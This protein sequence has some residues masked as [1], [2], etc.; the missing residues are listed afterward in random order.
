[1]ALD[2]K[3]ESYL[4]TLDRALSRVSVSDRSEIIL[5]IKSHVLDAVAKHPEQKVGDVLKALGEPEAVANR[6]LVERGLKPGKAPRSP[7][8]KWLTIGFLGTFAILMASVVFM[9]TYFSPII[10]IDENEE[11]VRILGGLISVN[12]GS[13]GGNHFDL[14]WNGRSTQESGSHALDPSQVDLVDVRFTNGKMDVRSGATDELAWDCWTVGPADGPSPEVKTDG[15][16]AVL[17]LSG[18]TMNKCAVTLPTGLK[19]RLVGS[20][21]R[22]ALERPRADT[23]VEMDNGKVEIELDPGRGYKFDLKLT[24]GR[25]DSFPSSDDPDAVRVKVTMDNG[26]ITRR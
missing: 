17:D 26:R 2:P 14:D 19:V 12:G 3:L 23:E 1:M 8:L 6:Y 13:G 24:N 11:Q 18:A 7:M 4:A 25:I 9:I 15:R 5:E 20:N 22:L 10:S 16:T 21:G